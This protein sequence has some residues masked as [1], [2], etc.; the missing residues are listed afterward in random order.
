MKIL[1]LT[2]SARVKG[3][4]SYLAEKFADGAISAGHEVRRFDCAL[5]NLRDCTGCGG[6]L[7]NGGECVFRDGMDIVKPAI[8]AADVVVFATPV[9][10]FGMSAQLKSTVDRF[11]S[12]NESLMSSKKKSV[13]LVTCA[14]DTPDTASALV[15]H[16]SKVIEYFGWEDAGKLIACSCT[17][18]E[19]LVGSEYEKLAEKMGAQI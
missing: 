9:Y 1:I 5:L 12:M 6:C 2:G 10:Y 18:K 17:E 4:S 7:E 16:W 3:T 13:L 14:D 11:Y 19:A 8:L 15:D